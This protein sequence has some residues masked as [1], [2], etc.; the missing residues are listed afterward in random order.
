MSQTLGILEQS[1]AKLGITPPPRCLCCCLQVE[2]LR[3]GKFSVVP[4][5]ALVPGDVVAVTTGV[6]PADCVLLTG[7]CIVDENMLTGK[8]MGCTGTVSTSHLVFWQLGLSLMPTWLKI[9][10][11]C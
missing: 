10:S 2:V 5:T 8:V 6:L 4:S 3:G 11:Q 1:T 7:E 9:C